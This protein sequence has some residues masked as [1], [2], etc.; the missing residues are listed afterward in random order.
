MISD[1]I[2]IKNRLLKRH[3][4]AEA[5]PEEEY[6]TGLLAGIEV[7]LAEIDILIEQE[8]RAF[9]EYYGERKR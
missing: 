3:Q 8:D 4:A 5:R 7:A 6:K 1:L 9:S 2:S